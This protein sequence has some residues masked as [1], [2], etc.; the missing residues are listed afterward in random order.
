MATTPPPRGRLRTPP[1]PTHECGYNGY[2]PYSG[3]PRR[4]KRLATRNDILHVRNQDGESHVSSD[5]LHSDSDGNSHYLCHDSD[6]ALSAPNSTKQ[7]PSSNSDIQHNSLLPYT[8]SSA[9]RVTKK[10]LPSL[11]SSHKSSDNTL[12]QTTMAVGMLPTPAK[13]PRKKNIPDS[14]AIAR[15]LFTNRARAMDLERRSQRRPRGKKYSGFSLES[16]HSNPE[17]NNGSV[18]IYTDVRDRIPTLNS[19]EDNPFISRPE[20][21]KTPKVEES[22]GKAKRRK[23]NEDDIDRDP[24]VDEMVNRDDGVLCVFRGKKIFRK[25]KPK[26]IDESDGDND[27]GLLG[28]M[29]DIPSS[30][31]RHFTRSSIKPRVLF[32]TADQLRT[33]A[34]KAKA[35]KVSEHATNGKEEKMEEQ[36]NASSQSEATDANNDPVTPPSKMTRLATPSTPLASGRSLRSHTKKSESE[37]TPDTSSSPTGNRFSPFDRWTR[38]KARSSPSGKG[39]KRSSSSLGHDTPHQSKKVHQ[40]K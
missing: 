18:E 24:A 20:E 23:V 3:S 8:K 13:T 14:G 1:A 38:I 40:S 4:S 12:Q 29:D 5:R 10:T 25:F 28:S 39:K 27:P 37:I 7:S 34:A 26:D 31:T 36:L 11:P 2:S 32:P 15:D 16:F 30:R 19:S 35:A 22:D 6:A 17:E 21:A 33:R 9:S